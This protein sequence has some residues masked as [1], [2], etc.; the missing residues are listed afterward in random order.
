MHRQYNHVRIKDSIEGMESATALQAAITM[1]I[2]DIVA[3]TVDFRHC[4]E[5]IYTILNFIYRSRWLGS[6]L[7][8]DG[9]WNGL[10]DDGE[11]GDM[12]CQ[13]L[14]AQPDFCSPIP[15]HLKQSELQSPQKCLLLMR[16]IVNMRPIHWCDLPYDQIS[17]NGCNSCAGSVKDSLAVFS[18]KAQPGL[19]ILRW[20]K[21]TVLIISVSKFLYW[22]CADL[23]AWS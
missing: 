12:L 23:R 19:Q 4:G 2:L 8:N 22:S 1:S 7:H 11:Q 15:A 6:C 13:R 21:I 10:L 16:S 14:H 9:V 3:V 5:Y 17:G 20:N 18:H